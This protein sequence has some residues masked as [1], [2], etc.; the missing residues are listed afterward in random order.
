LLDLIISGS[1]IPALDTI[2]TICRIIFITE[3]V[4]KWIAFDFFVYENLCLISVLSGIVFCFSR[5]F[6][7]LCIRPCFVSS[8]VQVLDGSAECLRWFFSL[9]GVRGNGD[10]L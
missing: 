6:F 7:P 9:F 8:S 1:A 10:F 5:K 4:L 3:M 2:N